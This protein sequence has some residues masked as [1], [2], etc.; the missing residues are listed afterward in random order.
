MA[1]RDS[2]FRCDEQCL[3]GGDRVV[4][5]QQSIN[6][7]T[8]QLLIE[9]I[10]VACLVFVAYAISRPD[11][12][13]T[14]GRLYDDVV[15]LSVGKSI[16]E[17]TGYRSIHMVGSPIHVK[18]PPVVPAIYAV[19]W[20]VFGSIAAVAAYA[21]WASIVAASSCAAV[22][23]WFAR[24]EL[25]VGRVLATLFVLAPL[26][27][28][29]TMFY[30]TGAMSEPWMLLGWSL[31]CLLAARVVRQRADGLSA[32]PTSVALGVVLALTVLTRTQA[33]PSVLA[34]IVGLAVMR[35]G[36]RALAT[37]F[38]S[39][40]IPLAVWRFWH[41]AM[42]ARGPLSPLPDQVSYTTWF[43]TNDLPTLVSF[44]ARVMR[45]TLPVYWVNTAELLLGWSSPKT[46]LVASVVLGCGLLGIVLVMRRFP[47]LALS[48]L[49]ML[50]VMAI[51]PV[52]DRFLTTLLPVLGLASA[53]GV[54]RVIGRMRPVVQR[55]AL[56]GAAIA[57]AVILVLN[58]R[59]RVESVR[60]APSSPMAHAINEIVRWVDANTTPDDHI[61][62]AW[63]GAIYLR[64]GRRTS[65]ANPEEPMLVP[66]VFQSP[67]RFLAGQILADA[68][69]DVIIWDGAPGRDGPALRRLAANC[70]GL[71]TAAPRD[72]SAAARKVYFYRVRRDVPCLER[73]AKSESG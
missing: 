70:P 69:D 22:L 57:A 44:A 25:Q 26:L 8:R 51:W 41:G 60:G 20:L 54:Q 6:T 4:S 31:G 24:R 40:S 33:V 48:L 17:G 67:N 29:R 35:V 23:W 73:F 1:V 53:F 34:I 46:L 10:V 32:V 38:T 14:L 43:P 12:V 37:V 13:A 21:Q 62:V 5:S 59:A 66:S 49:A 9:A 19:G 18:Y 16:A 52:Q 50:A 64:T 11:A 45:A 15:Y 68:V 28:E 63:G 61:M 27:A 56:G 36:V 58:A 2:A 55:G 30:F 71:M 65:I 7:S 72:S 3:G 47:P 42:M 39:M